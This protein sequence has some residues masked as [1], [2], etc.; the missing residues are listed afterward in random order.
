MKKTRTGALIV[1]VKFYD[2]ELFT[3]SCEIIDSK[4]QILPKDSTKIKLKSPY[5]KEKIIV[6]GKINTAPIL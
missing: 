6:V 2:D 3:N 1:F 4:I 5:Y